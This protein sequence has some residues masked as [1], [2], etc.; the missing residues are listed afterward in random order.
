DRP[1]RGSQIPDEDGTKPSHP[2]GD[3]TAR[4]HGKTQRIR[5]S[6]IVVGNRRPSH[7][8]PAPARVGIPDAYLIRVGSHHGPAVGSEG[9]VIDCSGLPAE[10]LFSRRHLQQCQTVLPETL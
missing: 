4:K 6:K 5:K 3:P 7:L 8:V 9:D 2:R 1:G 10:Y